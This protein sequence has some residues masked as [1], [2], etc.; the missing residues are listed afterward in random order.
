MTYICII[1]ILCQ[2]NFGKRKKDLIRSEDRKAYA[3]RKPSRWTFCETCLPDPCILTQ[4]SVSRDQGF[5][6]THQSSN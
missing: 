3:T 4:C 5:M 1:F 6:P 2:E